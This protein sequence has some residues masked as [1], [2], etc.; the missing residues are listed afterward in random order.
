[1]DDFFY[2]SYFTFKKPTNKKSNQ[3]CIKK[4]QIFWMTFFIIFILPFNKTTNKKKTSN[5]GLLFF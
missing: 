2:Y 3:L 5:Y 1:L 4:I